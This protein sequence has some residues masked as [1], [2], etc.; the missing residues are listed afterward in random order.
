VMAHSMADTLTAEASGLHATPE[1]SSTAG[2][3]QGDATVAGN[4]VLDF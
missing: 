3:T 4:A 1:V 2:A